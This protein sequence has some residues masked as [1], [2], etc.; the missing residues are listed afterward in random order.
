[1]PVGGAGGDNTLPPSPKPSGSREV[2][3]HSGGTSPT[4]HALRQEERGTARAG[5]GS[6]STASSRAHPPLPPLPRQPPAASQ[7]ISPVN[8]GLLFSYNT[9]AVV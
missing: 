8:T 4:G 1:M 2:I 5:A 6:D 9:G 3:L 7:N